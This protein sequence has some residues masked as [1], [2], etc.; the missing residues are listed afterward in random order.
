MD[1]FT[2]RRLLTDVSELT[3]TKMLVLQGVIKPQIS[4]NAA[5]R[6]Y[7]RAAVQRWVDSAQIKRVKRG[8]TI[9]L[10]RLQL[11]TLSKL[12]IFEK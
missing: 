6:Q 12:T 9:Y 1:T 3:A 11:E 8:N 7:G 4:Q 5:Y 10:D 2:L